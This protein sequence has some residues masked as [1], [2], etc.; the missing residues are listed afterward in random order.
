[1]MWIQ[2]ILLGSLII[3]CTVCRSVLCGSNSSRDPLLVDLL[4]AMQRSPRLTVS[5]PFAGQQQ[6]AP[7]AM[8]RIGWVQ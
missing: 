5:P 3:G 8:K 6:G 7:A 2:G 4:V 1:M